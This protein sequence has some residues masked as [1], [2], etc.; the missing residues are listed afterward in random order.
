MKSWRLFL[1]TLLLV[2]SGSP[3]NAQTLNPGLA[4]LTSSKYAKVYTLVYKKYYDV[5]RDK[6]LTNRRSAGSWTG[7][8]DE[9]WL[10]GTGVNDYGTAYA[11]IKYPAGNSRIDAYMNL[12]D[13]FIA[14]TLTGGARTAS[15]GCSGLYKRMNSGK[16]SSWRI[17]AGDSVYLLARSGGWCQVLY[18]SGSLWRIAWLP[19][20]DYNNLF[21]SVPIPTPDNG[22]ARDKVVAYARQILNY[23]WQT[24]GYILL[25]YSGYSPSTNSDGSLSITTPIVATGTV[26]GIPYT[27]SSNNTG[28][29][30]EKTFSQYK[31]LS[32]SDRLLLSKIYNY[33]G[34]RVGMKYGMSCATFVTDCILQGLT[35]KGLSTY[36]SS[37]IH[38]NSRWSQ[39]ITQG[40]KNNAGYSKLQKGDYLYRSGHVILVAS[41]NGSSI[42]AI[43]QTPPDYTRENCTN[44]KRIRIQLT[45]N[46]KARY[47]DAIQV[48]MQCNA[49]IKGTMGTQEST[50]TYS[51][52]NNK[53]YYP[54]YI[55]YDSSPAPANNGLA[56]NA[57]NFPD[58][59]FRAYIS[60]NID[61]NHDGYLSGSE[62]SNVQTL[63]LSSK[64]ISS[65]TGIKKFTNLASLYASNNNLTALDV[66]G[67]R[68]LNNLRIDNNSLTSLNVS[69]CSS[70]MMLSCASNRLSALD[71]SSCSNLIALWCNNNK[72]AWL[73]LRNNRNLT[74]LNGAS[75]TAGSL[76]AS[77]NGTSY[78][79][80]ISD[81][82]GSGR[83]S[84]VS[85]VKAIRSG[86][87]YY[88]RYSAG[89]AAF[90]S[91]PG[92]P[93]KIT[94]DY[95]PAVST[96]SKLNVTAP[97][98]GTTGDTGSLTIKY[99]LGT[100]YRGSSFYDYVRVSGGTAPYTASIVSGK[101]PAGISMSV[102]GQ[103]VRFTGTAASSA[104]TQTFTLRVRDSA[105]NSQTKQLRIYVLN[106]KTVSAS[107]IVDE[108]EIRL[109][110]FGED[111][112]NSEATRG[113]SFVDVRAGQDIRF[114]ISSTGE[115]AYA[116]VIM[117]GKVAENIQV[118]DEGTF[119]I[120]GELVSGGFSVRVKAVIEGQILETGE[121]YITAE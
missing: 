57:A 92:A 69:G 54:M 105:G 34:R 114:R 25:H 24:S 20:N 30:A 67:M 90:S 113:G 23:T 77:R 8:D 21:S 37:G 98:S 33:S 55:K 71:V 4:G 84:Y 99:E 101:L 35:G 72:F 40:S 13:A 62:I 111:I 68:N 83:V 76:K 104:T 93:E 53:G 36:A 6:N 10:I 19:E 65:L 1:C 15:S 78:Q 85:N 22:S 86:M 87:T 97:I 18:P 28:G 17:D 9:I 58:A 73:N 38:Q 50:Y 43:E 3:S 32:N 56:I 75:Q 52:L 110:A 107:F 80:N 61:T 46:G 102:F 47:Y 115:L 74:T 91:M 89:V 103:L 48:C 45:Y 118:S 95:S 12:Q 109:E 79:V 2:V 112:T 81:L 116:E 117:N 63:S 49:C 44:K 26:R 29:G 60:N 42:T 70:L 94:Y 11:H 59:N 82:V 66:S 16:N 14:G 7:E 121:I 106:R 88:G 41:N 108:P 119:T 27:L 120:P 5:F 31:A 39:Y 96:T 100:A 64:G 51:Q